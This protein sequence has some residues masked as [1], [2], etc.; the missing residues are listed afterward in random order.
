MPAEVITGEKDPRRVAKIIA[1]WGVK[2]VVLTFGS[3]GSQI[4]YGGKFY[5]IPAY[6]PQHCI[7]VTG[8]GDTFSTGYLY[9]RAKGLDCEEAGK[10]AAA[11]C[12]LKIEKPGPF[13]EDISRIERIIR[14]GANI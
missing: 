5:D 3:Y 7:D 2:E 9:C 6:E 10:F 14:L 1:S 8:C 4:Y 11:M 12:T 13:S